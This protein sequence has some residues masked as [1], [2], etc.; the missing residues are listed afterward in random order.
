MGQVNL[1]AFD[2]ATSVC[3]IALKMN[4]KLF[5]RHE[6]AAS[7]H[8][9]L[10]LPMID[11][12]LKEAN[13]DLSHIHAIAFGMGPGSFM[14]S[15]F[16]LSTAQG[17]AFGL[18]IPVIPVSTLHI[19]A[20]QAPTAA[21]VLAG[22]DARMQQLYVGLFSKTA[23][24]AAERLTEDQLI[25]PQALPKTLLQPVIAIGNAWEVHKNRL[26]EG[27]SPLQIIT[28]YPNAIDLVA[29]AETAWQ[30]GKCLSADQAS[31]FYLRSAVQ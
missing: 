30:A 3:T 13:A 14:G 1:L 7:D 11:A 26:P 17:L 8:S 21:Q 9:R 16:A 4:G 12:L 6:Q 20:Q 28:A 5:S 22:W 2:T 19:L 18:K 31:A 29:L 27:F 24:G 10:L 25:S 23:T 15:R